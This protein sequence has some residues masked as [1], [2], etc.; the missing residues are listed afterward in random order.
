MT[1]VFGF[2]HDEAIRSF[3]RAATAD[4][5][6][7]M[8]HWG[9]AWAL[10]PNYNMDID[11][12]RSKQ[13]FD[14]VQKAQ[15]LAASGP[16]NE[17]AYIAAF[18]G[19]YSPDPK[20]DRAALAQK[21]SQAMHDLMQRYPDDLDAATLYAESLMNLRPWKLWTL[22]GKAEEGTQDIIEV[23]RVV[24]ARDPNHIG[25]NHYYIHTMEASPT[26]EQA[27]E[28][29]K[30]LDSLVPD[31]GHLVHMPA[32]IYGRTGDHAAAARANRAGAEADRAYFTAG[33]PRGTFYEMGYFAHNL[34]FLVDSEMMQGNFA[35]A[36]RAAQ[37]L[38]DALSPHLDMM[39][40]AESMV[41]SSMSLLMR[42]GKVE[43]IFA[44]PAPDEKRPVLT[45]WWHFARGV[46]FARKGRIPESRSERRALQRAIENVPESALFG[47][48]G[49][50]PA[51]N[52]LKLAVTVL[53]ARIA[54]A[55]GQQPQAI[56]LWQQAV[57]AGDQ[58]PYDEPPIWF[59][60]LRESLGAALLRAG[61]ATG[62]ERTFRDDLARHPRNARA[63]Y[64][65]SQSLERQRKD[66]AD[67]RAAFTDAWRNAD[68][69]MTIDGL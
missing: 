9:I 41:A 46:A 4:P 36:Q 6:A 33:G 12:P 14:E 24:L 53:D 42:F 18:A 50:T 16:E 62:A 1:Y 10:G 61:D 49:L 3:E 40:M 59:Y 38:S 64:G 31:M 23:L 47:G 15:T 34:H 2:N 32:H 20:S 66:S 56:R 65:L 5:S 58:V 28:S 69:Q 22:D 19:R 63:L 39:P 21:Y 30:R 35:G 45:A 67:A 68:V 26:P 60:P 48:T 7:A 57:A 43:E 51:S 52:I 27:L 29:A 8:P 13:A 17:R 54:E 25:A 44:L 11:D 55:S 37:E